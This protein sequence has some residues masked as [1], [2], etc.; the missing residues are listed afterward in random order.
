[1]LRRIDARTRNTCFTV[2]AFEQLKALC[3]NNVEF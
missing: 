2:Q 1:M 3:A